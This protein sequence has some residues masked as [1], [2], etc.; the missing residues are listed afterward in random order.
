MHLGGVGVEQRVARRAVEWMLAELRRQ[1]E[2]AFMFCMCGLVL[3]DLLQDV[4]AARNT[5]TVSC[6]RHSCRDRCRLE[7]HGTS[8]PHV[9]GDGRE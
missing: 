1:R 8:L 5:L 9:D 3:T 7:M 4:S 2:Y 6:S